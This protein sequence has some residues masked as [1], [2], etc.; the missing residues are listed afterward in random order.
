MVRRRGTRGERGFFLRFAGRDGAKSLPE[1]NKTKQNRANR[2]RAARAR[3]GRV[4]REGTHLLLHL[5]SV[6]GN[7]TTLDVALEGLG[8]Q[9]LVLEIVAGVA[10]VVVGDVETAVDS[11]LEGGEDARTRGGAHE[12][13]V[14]VALERTTL[15]VL[16][17]HVV[18]IAK[19]LGVALVRLGE[20][21]LGQEAARAQETGGVG[22][23]IVGEA[24]LHAV[25]G[26][27]VGVRRADGHV[28]LDGGVDHLAD[29][30]AVGEANG[31][32]VLGRVV[33]VL[34]LQG[35]ALTGVVVR[36]A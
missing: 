33:L 19:V 2:W 1:E 18:V 32:P 36:L 31:E 8:V 11:A 30:I 28:T 34:V 27:L 20:V 5:L 6:L 29:D 24:R 16:S 25:L 4:G 15:P 26:K 7:H 21:V 35:E 9:R 22:G 13:G 3:S 17:L 14:E 12:T 23:G 10:L